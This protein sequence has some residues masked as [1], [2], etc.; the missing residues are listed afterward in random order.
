MSTLS[1]S[2]QVDELLAEGFEA[3]RNREQEAFDL[4]AGPHGDDI[5]LFGAGGLGRRTVEK[6]RRHGIE[7]RAFADNNR[8]L[9]GSRVSDVPVMS[10]EEAAREFGKTSVFVVTIW[11]GKRTPTI[12]DRMDERIAA[13]HALGCERVVP[14]AF[15]Y[16]KYPQG[17]LPYYSV[18]LPHKV[19]EQAEE[20]RAA[21][22]LWADEP[23]RLEYVNQLRWR[24]HLDF[25]GLAEP[26]SYPIY[27][28]KHLCPIRT[29]EVFIDCGAYDGDTVEL[30]V[31]ETGGAF[32]KIIALEPDPANFAK[33]RETCKDLLQDAGRMT[34]Y[35]LATGARNERLYLLADGSDAA[36]IAGS[37]D[38]GVVEVESVALDD[39]LADTVPTYVKMDIEGSEVATLTGMKRIIREQEP[40]LAICTYH[41]QNDLWKI[42]LLI[43]SINPNYRFFLH[44][45]KLEVW[46]LVCYAIPRHRLAS[47]FPAT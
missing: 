5:V 8:A 7:P 25:A 30:F 38:A 27:F 42:P 46:D 17:V 14:F 6:L 12:E 3:A 33:L 36:R 37:A 19:H 10:P 44:P 26:V 47:D 18:D 31:E 28:P 41:L 45:H 35:P 21:F 23:S 40:V 20:V 9:W 1:L 22:A 16:W 32:K 2:N 39:F 13:L 29:D 11:G 34:A 24:L 15:L 43:H 4:L